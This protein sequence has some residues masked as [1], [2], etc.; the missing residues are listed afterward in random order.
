MREFLHWRYLNDIWMYDHYVFHAIGLM[1]LAL[2]IWAF[3]ED[4]KRGK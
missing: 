3:L 2:V 1:L 4:R